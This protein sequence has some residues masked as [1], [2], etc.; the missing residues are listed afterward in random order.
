[1]RFDLNEKLLTVWFEFEKN[2]HGFAMPY[3]YNEDPI[4]KIHL[5]WLTV[6]EHHKVKE[7]YRDTAECDGFILKD[8]QGRTWT[9]QY[10]VAHYGQLSDDQDR[11]FHL[12]LDDD[13]SYDFTSLHETHL[14]SDVIGTMARGI[15]DLSKME[16]EPGSR[17][18]FLK[19]NLQKTLDDIDALLQQQGLAVEFR[20]IWKD[21]P[22]ITRAV[23]VPV[24]VMQE[25]DHCVM[26]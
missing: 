19:A 6:E 10:P 8:E 4:Q 12:K 11:R 25:D 3:L 17:V 21:A 13:E 24:S 5:A 23:I 1:M 14:L 18:E 22:D 2:N 26:A 16:A 20:P 15:K 9:N 7:Y